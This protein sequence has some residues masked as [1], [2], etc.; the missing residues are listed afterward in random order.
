MSSAGHQPTPGPPCLGATPPPTPR[1]LPRVAHRAGVS[2]EA[3]LYLWR[4]C[5]F[6]AVR[7]RGL[8]RIP[9]VAVR[10]STAGA[11]DMAEVVGWVDAIVGALLFWRPGCCFY[12]AYTIVCVLRRHGI[13]ATLNFG[14][15]NLA[16]PRYRGAH[17]WV[18]LSGALLA[19]PD[20]TRETYSVR[21]GE[22][23]AGIVFWVDG[24]G[25]E[26]DGQARR[27]AERHGPQ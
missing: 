27:R 19:E 22:G 17:C 7:R 1:R 26:D 4:A 2:V 25:T 11:T 14:Y 15:R 21:L 24:E 18:T 16:D 5:W 9:A 23:E 10:A 3:L 20:A 6:R 12:R 13:P 8:P